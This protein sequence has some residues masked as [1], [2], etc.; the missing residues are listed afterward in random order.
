[1]A[2]M[3]VNVCVMAQRSGVPVNGATIRAVREIRGL[4]LE[5]LAE[6]VGVDRSTL[7][8]WEL[9]HHRPARHRLER[10]ARALGVEYAA[11]DCSH[12]LTTLNDEQVA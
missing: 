2:L 10:I 1:M 5:Q 4:T 6:R 8:N 12:L 7:N 3:F 11:L 9:E